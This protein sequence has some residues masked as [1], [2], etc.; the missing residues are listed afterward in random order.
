MRR[1]TAVALPFLLAACSRNPSVLLDSAGPH[2]AATGQLF[3]IFLYVC[4]AVWALVLLL[5]GFAMTRRAAVIDAV[6]PPSDTERRLTRW[7]ACGAG[8]TVL[9][10]TGFVAAS[11]ATDRHLIGIESGRH[12]EIEVTGR[13]WWWELRYR[14]ATPSNWFVTANELHLP[15]G[16]P[17]RLVMRSGDVIHSVWI[18]NLAGK[19][20]IIPGRANEMVIQADEAGTWHGRCAEFC[21]LQHAFMQLTVVAQ[22]EAE[23]AQWLEAQR[24]PGAEPATDEQRH[25]QQVFQQ[26]PCAICHTIRGPDAGSRSPTAPD[27]THLASRA[28][29]GAGAAPNVRGYLGGWILDPHG[30]KPGVLMPRIQLPADDFQA[31][32]AYLESL[33]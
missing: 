11:Y 7:V 21:G 19:R 26:G 24:R 16:R 22:P 14:D 30:I 5:L 9:V 1:A 6:T 33:R 25:G 28:S 12:L 15:V 13:Q 10:L 20:D 31:L 23:F 17:V 27:L 8:A 18:P 3:W 29:I 2:A 4:A 32:L